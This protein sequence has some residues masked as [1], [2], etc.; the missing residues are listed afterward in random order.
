MGPLFSASATHLLT[1]I[2]VIAAAVGISLCQ[3][4]NAAGPIVFLLIDGT[5]LPLASVYSGVFRKGYS[6]R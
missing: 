2:R 6:M 5:S 4:G 3:A 1:T